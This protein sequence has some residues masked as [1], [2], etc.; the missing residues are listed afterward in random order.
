MSVPD[1]LWSKGIAR[2]ANNNHMQNYWNEHTELKHQ[3]NYFWD[4]IKHLKGIVWIRIGDI[5]N[6]SKIIDFLDNPITLL[7][8]DGDLDIPT[9]LTSE[10]YLK[11]LNSD[12]IY[13][14]YTQNWDGYQHTK[15]GVFPIGLD[16]HSYNGTLI[17]NMP[18]I[19]TD[20]ISAFDKLKILQEVNSTLKPNKLNVRKTHI[21]CDIHKNPTNPDRVTLFNLLKTNGIIDFLSKRL[22]QRNIWEKYGEYSL[23][24]SAPGNGL[25]CHRTWE[26]LLLGCIVI[27]KTSSLDILYKNLP[28]VI[29]EEWSELNSSDIS[30]KI[31]SWI[32]TYSK[33]TETSY[34]WSNLSA[35]KWFKQLAYPKINNIIVSNQNYT[36]SKL[37]RIS[38]LNITCNEYPNTFTF[39]TYY[40]SDTEFILK[41]YKF[42]ENQYYNIAISI[43]DNNGKILNYYLKQFSET[44][45]TVFI[46][47]N[48]L[49]S[50]KSIYNSLS[51]IPKVIYQTF[52]YKELPPVLENY[53]RCWKQLNPEYSYQFY[54]DIECRIFIKEYFDIDV[55]NAFDCLRPGAFKAD[56]WRYCILYKNGGVYCD[57]SLR[58]NKPL[59]DWLPNKNGLD[60]DNDNDNEFIGVVDLPKVRGCIWNGFIAS[61]P[62]CVFLK[63]AIDNIILNCKSRN[64]GTIIL[65]DKVINAKVKKMKLDSL[66]I[67]GPILLAN[68]INQV[69]KRAEETQFK[70]SNQSG[71]DGNNNIS[72]NLLKLSQN[73]NMQTT[74]SLGNQVGIIYDKYTLLADLVKSGSD[75][76]YIHHNLNQV[77]YDF[78]KITG[79]L[80]ID[81]EELLPVYQNILD[82]YDTYSRLVSPSIITHPKTK[83]K[84]M[85]L[86]AIDKND[87]NKSDVLL[88]IFN[89]KTKSS[90]LNIPFNNYRQVKLFIYNNKPL[91]LFISDDNLYIYMLDELDEQD[92]QDTHIGKKLIK[93]TVPDILKNKLKWISPLINNINNTNN[94]L[95]QE[96]HIII[97]IKPLIILVYNIENGTCRL[98]D[99]NNEGVNEYLNYTN[100]N[101]N[102]NLI[103]GTPIIEIQPDT[104]MGFI[105]EEINI[106]DKIKMLYR[107]YGDSIKRY[108]TKLIILKKINN[109]F[110]IK[111][112]TN[113]FRFKNMLLEYPCGLEIRDNKYRVSV[114]IN[115]YNG[116]I[117][118]GSVDNIIN[119]ITD[120]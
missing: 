13:K 11:L 15:F 44:S 92:A 27:T 91:L 71:Y 96:L 7:T 76:Y 56:L 75:N 18:I 48:L 94:N 40:I 104:Y 69:L 53:R 3:T 115:N 5:N 2:F 61:K 89:H 82:K 25:D 116:I 12:K 58:P 108:E 16:L 4:N 111:V 73:N 112:I 93:I 86:I 77:Y 84:M 30:T 98:L 55:L 87:R 36:L 79:N 35:I 107:E 10:C 113:N 117:C 99:N 39:D 33:L 54:D 14:W 31:N 22:L 109:L 8:T 19:T 101:T 26:L 102:N 100:T 63:K 64:N 51:T 52:A 80:M 60:N 114:Q 78:P 74:I 88:I 42:S 21:F 28:V 46:K 72:F 37:D 67:T 49:T 70:I 97:N 65:W 119:N 83:L 105:S 68:S 120:H 20:K 45:K 95:D 57:L 106:D 103:L 118:K 90:K 110:T 85:S 1:I 24:I 81:K 47:H 41:I 50:K 66:S 43:K 23:V 6:F 38:N 9:G 62:G 34:I 29:L 17:D 59:R 32:N